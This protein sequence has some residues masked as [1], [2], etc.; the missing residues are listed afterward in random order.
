MGHGGAALRHLPAVHRRAQPAALQ[1]LDQPQRQSR[2]PPHF[3]CQPA[4]ALPG[5]LPAGQLPFGLGRVFPSL[6]GPGQSVH[7]PGPG[8][9]GLGSAPAEIPGCGAAARALQTADAP[10]PL[11]LRPALPAA[12]QTAGAGDL[13]GPGHRLPGLA[14]ALD[15]GGLRLT[16][17]GNQRAGRR[18]HCAL[19]LPAAGYFRPAYLQHGALPALCL[20]LP[21]PGTQPGRHGPDQ[22]RQRASSQGRRARRPG[23]PAGGPGRARGACIC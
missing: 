6:S 2:Q 20:L 10:D 9:S 22:Q 5:P 17:T 3:P 8:L 19:A 23:P 11:R 21:G 13:D 18:F 7:H 1:T 12:D 15:Q 16:A 4:L 14:A